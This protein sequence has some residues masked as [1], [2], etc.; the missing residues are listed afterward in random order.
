[1]LSSTERKKQVQKDLR[2]YKRHLKDVSRKSKQHEVSK[3]QEKIHR[4][5]L[6]QQNQT[7]IARKESFFRRHGF[8]ITPSTGM[9][10][11]EIPEIFCL[12]TNYSQSMVAIKEFASSIYDYLG[13][14]IK[15]D[16][17]KCNKAD[18][19]A[20]FL[21]QIIRQELNII[22]EE[23][24][25]RLT[26]LNLKTEVTLIPS[27]KP[28]VMRLLIMTGYPVDIKKFNSE[29]KEI[30]T[31]QPIDDMGLFKGNSR[32]QQVR[33]NRKPVA[34]Q[35]V[36]EYLNKCL[37]RHGYQLTEEDKNSVGGIVG[38]VLSNCEDHSLSDA[39][40]I[41][42]NFS[43]DLKESPDTSIGELNITIMNFGLSYYEAFEETKKNNHHIYDQ[44]S[45]LAASTRN[46]NP[47]MKFGD[48]QLFTLIMMSD[49][50]SRLK[51]K[52]T[53]RGTGTIKF[54][55]SFIELGD[56]EDKIKGYVPNLSILTGNTQLIC[57]N[58][59]KP[60]LKD[61]VYC[62]S[63]NPEND[64]RVP[65]RES[66][67]KILSEK[68]PGTLLSVKIYLNKQHLDKKYGGNNYDN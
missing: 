34:T 49:Q 52:E 41:T 65:P 40:Y 4:Y 56:F 30:V 7:L 20:L 42:A 15:L 63:L 28:D 53:S 22:I 57:D 14:E 54:L 68:F 10:T 50:V 3:R 39:W 37:D 44:V 6:K 38:E 45:D 9:I 25:K 16:F 18:T 12:C 67:L 61:T 27:K 29:N 24:G 46:K 64:L 8:F 47:N 48:E 21:L 36:V 5:Q 26:L 23:M 32:Q 43:T 60:F 2:N 11:V 13:F 62:L 55:R 19:A 33:E 31:M 51:Y 58:E 59:L 66:H 17:S 35:R 1:M